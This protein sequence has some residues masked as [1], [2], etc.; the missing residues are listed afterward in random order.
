MK[1]NITP[2]NYTYCP[3]CSKKLDVKVEEEKEWKYCADCKWT[4]YPHVAGAA[5]AV[6]VKDG[7]VLMVKRNREPY[8]GTWMFPAGFIDFGEHP[9]DALVR[10]VKEEVGLEVTKLKLM[11]IV[12]VDDDPRS[13]GHFG[14]FYEVE[15]KDGNVKNND[16][17]ENTEIVWFDVKNLPTVGWH[18]HKKIIEKYL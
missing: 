16:N 3:F 11:E 4:Y 13:M 9:E 1:L 15:V 12:Q 14:Y 2:P 5:C 17:E 7:K 6:I 8:K 10:E 18:G